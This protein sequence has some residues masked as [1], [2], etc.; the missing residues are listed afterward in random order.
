MDL[1]I[2]GDVQF[3]SRDNVTIDMAGN[4]FLRHTH[5]S[6]NGTWDLLSDFET[7]YF[8][9]FNS[10]HIR[11]NSHKMIFERLDSDVEN[12]RQWTLANSTIELRSN[13][14][15]GTE[16]RID[17]RGFNLDAGSSTLNITN[18]GAYSQYGNHDSDNFLQWH[19][20]DFYGSP[21]FY[22][23]HSDLRARVVRLF[24]NSNLQG[25]LNF[26][27][28]YLEP[29]YNYEFWQWNPDNH[30]ISVDTLDASGTCEASISIS[31]SYKS[32]QINIYSDHITSGQNLIIEDIAYVGGT[33]T[34]TQSIDYGNTSGFIIDDV[35]GRELFWV[36]GT[37]EWNDPAHWSLST[38]GPGGECVPTAV[39]NVHFDEN[40]FTSDDQYVVATNYYV[41]ICRDFIWDGPPETTRFSRSDEDGGCCGGFNVY[42]S[43][44]V[45]TPFNVDFYDIEFK[46][47]ESGHI[48]NTSGVFVSYY[49]FDAS[50]EWTLTDSLKA[51]TIR[52]ISGDFNTAGHNM[53][54]QNIYIDAIFEE[55][56]LSLSSSHIKLHS[57]GNGSYGTLTIWNGDQLNMDP[58]MST[59]E[60]TSAQNPTILWEG[61]HA[62]HNVLFSSPV[63]TAY[64]TRPFYDDQR[65]GNVPYN[66]LQLNSDAFIYGD[67]S[68]D[69]LLFANGRS[70][71]LES[72]KVQTVKDHL[73]I[74]GNNCIQLRLQSSQPGVASIIQKSSGT[75]EGDFIQ[76]QDQIARGGASFLAGANSTDISNNAGWVFES[77]EDYVEFGLL[78]DDVVFCQGETSLTINDEDLIGALSYEWNDGSTDPLLTVNGPGTY[79]LSASYANN[80]TLID[81]IRVLEALDFQVDLGEDMTLC[82]GETLPIDGDLQLHGATYQ[83]NDGS[84]SAQRVLDSTGVYS[85][86]ADLNGCTNSDTLHLSYVEIP[87]F[88]LNANSMVCQ[89]D[90][91]ILDANIEGAT[92]LWSTGSTNPILE[93]TETDQYWL[94]ISKEGCE[95]SDTLNLEFIEPPQ[96]DLGSDLLVCAEE[97]VTLDATVAG[98]TYLW[99]TGDMI[100]VITPVADTSVTYQVTTS[101]GNCSTEDSIRINVKPLPSIDLGE[102]FG[103]CPDEHFELVVTTD[104]DSFIWADGIQDISREFEIPGQF[105]VTGFLNGCMNQEN[106]EVFQFETNFISLGEDTLICDDVTYPVNITIPNGTYTWSDG[107]TEGMRQLSEAGLYN[108]EVFDGN[109][110]F[111]DSFEL[112][113]R[114]C[115]YFSVFQPNVFSPNND[116]IN[117]EFRLEFDP[118]I[119][120]QS[121]NLNIFD[122]WGNHLFS[123]SD[124]LEGWNGQKS[125]DAM[126]SDVYVYAFQ[127]EYIDDN[128]P[129]KFSGGGDILL[130]K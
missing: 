95:D 27:R 78:G 26:D 126:Q 1:Q 108:V 119:Q 68:F 49:Q 53:D 129:G 114:E 90:T 112:M 86:T 92:V 65:H 75:V 118:L 44:D 19:H 54:L 42:G 105:S 128:G 2:N 91:V 94:R 111:E 100:P 84:E 76:M 47:D 39:D 25:E 124:H 23:D 99:S 21:A 64:I 38:G 17:D 113:T 14:Y 20:I 123:S 71:T 57:A 66:K 8:L 3:L 67:H 35:A 107:S 37:G 41:A 36:G 120:V 52:F 11:T 28:L 116:G 16:I 98:A 22:V 45:R 13:R 93:V 125:S 130:V 88:G 81:S 31:S 77:P 18:G 70:Y 51:N 110:Y 59:I 33:F 83:W 96:F 109:C 74:R 121:F 87:E 6:G 32:Q 82:P 46:G 30:R 80:C 72:Q 127:I 4:K 117:D 101:F 102:D 50:G 122:R 56:N 104:A 60:L 61:T 85:L 103:V 55:A 106:V 10:G 62:L 79:W 34:A 12:I 15:W 29:G 89:G 24:G 115:I 73:Q 97:M 7:E 48:I 5:F 69:T 9:F 40:S 43:F 58:G 63:G